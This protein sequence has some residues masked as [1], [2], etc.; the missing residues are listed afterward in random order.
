DFLED[1]VSNNLLDAFSGRVIGVKPLCQIA[2]ERSISEFGYVLRGT[3]FAYFGASFEYLGLSC[4]GTNLPAPSL[5]VNRA[6]Q[7]EQ[8]FVLI[9]HVPVL[10]E[11]QLMEVVHVLQE[12]FHIP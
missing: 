5:L 6:Q 2:L 9:L 8:S 4:Q 7:D 10:H 12:K 1:L 11:L 3:I